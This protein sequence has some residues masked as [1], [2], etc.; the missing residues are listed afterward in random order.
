MLKLRQN[1]EQQALRNEIELA[2][3]EEKHAIEYEQELLSD[4]EL[5]R[6][7]AQTEFKYCYATLHNLWHLDTKGVNPS[8]ENK[9]EQ[10]TIAKS[11]RSQGDKSTFV[12]PRIVYDKR[13]I[14]DNYKTLPYYYFGY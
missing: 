8:F 7:D 10:K 3:L 6:S 11:H 1:V 14:V 9:K 2:K 5:I 12:N 4:D 13:V